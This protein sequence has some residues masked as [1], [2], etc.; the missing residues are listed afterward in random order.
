MDLKPAAS[1][2]RA[3]KLQLHLSE[4]RK[5]SVWDWNFLVKFIPSRAPFGKV[6]SRVGLGIF[7]FY[8]VDA[9]V[10]LQPGGARRFRLFR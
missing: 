5:G 9:V 1:T 3:S 8:S 10:D 6:R 7:Y 2:R 4:I